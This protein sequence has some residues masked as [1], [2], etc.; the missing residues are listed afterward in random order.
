MSIINEP[1][2]SKAVAWS[3]GVMA[4]FIATV[5]AFFVYAGF[6]TPLGATG[7]VASIASAF[8]E[9]IMLLILRSLFKTRYVLTDEELVIETTKLIGGG[10]R[11]PLDSIESMEQ[12][13]IPFGIRL[14]GASFHGGYYHIPSLGKAYLAITNLKDGLLV[15]TRQGNYI[16]TPKSPLGFKEAIEKRAIPP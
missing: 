13:L 14:F 8:V 7:L 6:F 12:T 2:V 3:Y 15:R 9:F 5:I 11:I 4:L 10:K 16:I 1:E